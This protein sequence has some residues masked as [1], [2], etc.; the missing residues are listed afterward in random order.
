MVVRHGFVVWL[1]LGNGF[2][3]RFGRIVVVIDSGDWT[4]N[5]FVPVT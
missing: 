2:R 5:G 1:F 3:D 4:C